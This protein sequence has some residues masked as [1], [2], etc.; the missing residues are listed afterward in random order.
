MLTFKMCF[1]GLWPCIMS[2]PYKCF[3][4]VKL[5]HCCRDGQFIWI[6]FCSGWYLA[7]PEK[8]FRQSNLG[9]FC[10]HLLLPLYSNKKLNLIF[11][12]N[13]HFITR[14]QPQSF[15]VWVGYN[16]PNAPACQLEFK[17][18][19]SSCL[20]V[21]FIHGVWPRPAGNIHP[22]I[23]QIKVWLILWGR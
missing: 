21:T 13:F 1:L 7:Q 17:F 23:S 8:G 9:S 3:T 2:T 18:T 15:F 14:P 4:A 10:Q 16:N 19:P 6:S 22:W 12:A 5:H 20:I 11:T